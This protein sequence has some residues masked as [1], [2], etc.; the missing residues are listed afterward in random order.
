MY[1]AEK[2]IGSPRSVT[3][4][5]LFLSL[6]FLVGFLSTAIIYSLSFLSLF[7]FFFFISFA[8]LF[9]RYPFLSTQFCLEWDWN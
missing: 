5:R 9:V 7:Y 2:R 3:L 4:Q 1:N 8:A 6:H